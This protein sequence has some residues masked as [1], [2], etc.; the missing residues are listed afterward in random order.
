M[1]NEQVCLLCLQVI[2]DTGEKHPQKIN[3]ETI[4]KLITTCHQNYIFS[5]HGFDEDETCDLCADCYHLIS[6]MEEIRMQI[7]LL[8]EEIGSKMK[9]IQATILHT[10]SSSQIRNNGKEKIMQIRDMF[11]RVAGENEQPDDNAEDQVKLEHIFPGENTEN[12]V[13]DEDEVQVKV[14]ELQR[15][16]N[17]VDLDPLADL[18][19]QFFDNDDLDSICEPSIVK[20]E[21]EL[22]IND[23][24]EETAF[25]I[26]PFPQT[27]S[28]NP[29]GNPK[30]TSKRKRE[31]SSPPKTRTKQSKVQLDGVP[32]PE[33]PTPRLSLRTK[34]RKVPPTHGENLISSP[35]KTHPIKTSNFNSESSGEDDSPDND[36]TD[37]SRKVRHV[38]SIAT[39]DAIRP[40]KC[41]K[42]KKSFLIEQALT[43]HTAKFHGVP[44]LVPLCTAKFHSFRM[45]DAHLKSDH[46]G[47]V[48]YQCRICKTKF[49]YQGGL[50]MHMVMRHEKGEKKLSCVKCEKKF[51]LEDNLA[52]HL[53]LHEVEGTKPVVCDMCDD[54]FENEERLKKHMEL[55]SHTR[56]FE[57]PQCPQRCKSRTE[58]DRHLRTHTKEKADKCPHCDHVAGGIYTLQRHIAI[59]HTAGPPSHTCHI[60]GKGFYLLVDLKSHMIRHDE[61]LRKKCDTCDETFSGLSSLHSH[62]IKVHG[63]AP[64]VCEECGATFTALRGF[65]QHKKVHVD[66]KRHQCQTCGACFLKPVGL[67]EHMKIH[68]DERPFPCA[69]CDRAFKSRTNMMKHVLAIHT[70]GYVVPTPY[71]CPHCD[72][73]CRSPFIL[74]CHIRQ[75]HTGERPFTCDQCEKAFAVKSALTLHLKTAHGVVPE[76][77]DRM[78]RSKKEAFRVEDDND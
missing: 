44:C 13:S 63:Q 2:D 51:C 59:V 61:T 20:E 47:L 39:S 45:R 6:T 25:C 41:T 1:S 22:I 43:R 65:R 7:S 66:G 24:D 40:H 56:P 21:E 67:R 54:R 73:A 52:R 28:T 64:L 23:E 75:A 48:P 58:L 14:E 19:E 49:K 46:D 4:C 70:P 38:D 34:K 12:F 36:D 60:C 3:I 27:N 69:H 76:K 11:L 18:G 31:Y 35:K 72:K 30:R 77:K 57:C 53:K 17:S 29:K 37:W 55:R 15:N 71:K 10:S 78:P 26:V 68:V 9:Q 8:E 5:Q 33:A 74:K 42:C 32:T 50:S 62:R 16:D